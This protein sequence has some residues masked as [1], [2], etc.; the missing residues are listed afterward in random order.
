MNILHFH[1]RFDVNFKLQFYFIVKDFI[2]SYF[3]VSNSE[4]SLYDFEQHST[5]FY[6]VR[7]DDD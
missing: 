7:M 1:L 3:K 6:K 4:K 5:V 2:Y